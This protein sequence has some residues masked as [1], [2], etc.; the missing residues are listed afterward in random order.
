MQ[1]ATRMQGGAQGAAGGFTLIELM[2]TLVVLAIGLALAIPTYEDIHQR[3]ETTAEAQEL[4]AFL[5]YAQ[6]EAIKANREVSVQLSH[7]SS[8]DWCVGA[9]E[10]NSGCDCT[11][12]DSSAADFCSLSGIRHVMDNSAYDRS[13][14]SSFSGGDT[15]VYDPIRGIKADVTQENSYL[16]E[17]NN[18]NWAL[19]VYV[20]PT[21]RIRL[22]NPDSDKKVPG[23]ELCST[24][25]IPPIVVLP[26]LVL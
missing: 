7:T 20:G 4:A 25:S 26:P 6:G 3:R 19:Q 24:L 5:A 14:M 18:D 16:I 9:A 22:C 13:G 17:S 15:F 12:A 1:S 23:F 8:T 21:G 2:I 10:G 11:E